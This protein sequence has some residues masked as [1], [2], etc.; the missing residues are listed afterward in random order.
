MK[1]L[2]LL[3]EG[4]VAGHLSHLYDNRELT[5]NEI[6]S[7][8]RKAAGGKLVGTEKTDG[9][10]IYLGSRGG[11]A[12]Y[13]RNK[14][15][16]A[17]GGR[18]IRDLKMRQFA[19]GDAIKD[20][21]LRAFRSFQK[22]IDSMRP[23]EQAA[24]FGQNGEIF[25]NTEIQGPGASNVV[26]YDANVLSIH[27][28]GHKRYIP[29]TNKVEV[30]DAEQNSRMLDALL[31]RFEESGS[32][33]DFS[34]R[35][36]AVMQLQALSDDR[37]Y[38]E[39]IEKLKD[40]GFSGS[41]T[42]G[43][44]L[45]KGLEEFLR[46]E[47]SY[48][49]AQT[50]KDIKD[51]ILNLPGAKN[52]R[53]IYQGMR[54]EE[55]TS[56]RDII[57]D[58]SK[59]L[60]KI[61]FP[62]EDA[63]H[64]FSVEMLK[65]MESAYILD[66]KA[67]LQRLRKEVQNAIEQISRYGGPGAEEAHEVLKK[68]L[69]KL[70]SHDNINTTVEGFVFQLGDQMYKFTGNFAP[71]NQLLGL[72]KYGRGTAPAIMSQGSQQLS[73]GVKMVD[74]PSPADLYELLS[75][76]ESIG[77]FPGGFK[78]PHKGH[79][80][81][82]ETMASEVEFPIVIMGGAAKTRP[83]SI[84][85]VPIDFDTAAKIWEIYANDAGVN[86]Y[87][88][89][90]PPGGN[91]MHIAYDILQNAKPGQRVNMVAGAKDGNRFRGQAE[92][93]KPEGVDLEVDP[94]PNIIDPDTQKPM[95]ATTFREA[96]E[97]GLDITKFIPEKSYGSV[98]KILQ[99]LGVSQAPGRRNSDTLYE[100]VVEALGDPRSPAGNVA[101]QFPEILQNIEGGLSNIPKE[102]MDQLAP[103]FS[104]MGRGFV[105]NLT[106][107]TGE[108]VGGVAQQATARTME[109]LGQ[110]QKQ[111]AQAMEAEAKEKK[112]K[113]FQQGQADAVNEI[114][115]AGGGAVQGYV[116]SA[117]RDEDDEDEEPTIFREDLTEEILNYFLQ[118]IA[119]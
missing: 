101:G 66:N 33:T 85:D 26:N 71:I 97:Q 19:G 24:V 10:N 109:P 64:D 13:A 9:F 40:A 1:K 83:R 42:I 105:D 11:L 100:M 98:N 62:I 91:P 113:E 69:K 110:F 63:I 92:Q 81:A 104:D 38:E 112:N 49:G 116:G 8:L 119:R 61:I 47:M 96:I 58:G 60:S 31:N 78:P 36:T 37:P 82:A 3:L 39:A 89:Q 94:V 14:G 77:V 17:A 23:E 18:T 93:Y 20:V 65:G 50:Q 48:F 25:Y 7:I 73:E 59:I 99:T 117:K 79:F 4:G 16:M 43:N 22:A 68:Q 12:L 107:Q 95:S 41:M 53:L 44:Y 6:S 76:Y 67:E 111:L 56:I 74:S 57:K 15:D 54:D 75:G 72:F 2:Y 90:A 35:R 118:T 70:K 30:V 5:F 32:G 87:I 103:M 52:L 108:I 88:L 102:L 34:V 114:S 55:K 84:N 28:G 45:E 21:Y 29:D 80:Q 106:G 27:H 86:F 51:K 115:S 46:S